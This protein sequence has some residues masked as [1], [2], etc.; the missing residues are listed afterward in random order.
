MGL[1]NRT[2]KKQSKDF[3]ERRDSDEKENAECITDDHSR[4]FGSR[5]SGNGHYGK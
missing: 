2:K 4:R 3:L 5:G 1:L